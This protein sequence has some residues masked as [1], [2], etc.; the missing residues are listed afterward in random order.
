M[1]SRDEVG[2]ARLVFFSA[3]VL[4]FRTLLKFP[5]SKPVQLHFFDYNRS[6]CGDAKSGVEILHVRPL[7]WAA[8]SQSYGGAHSRTNSFA[9]AGVLHHGDICKRSFVFGSQFG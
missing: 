2:F 5:E 1:F 7:P 4:F 9:D 3:F 8:N 6:R